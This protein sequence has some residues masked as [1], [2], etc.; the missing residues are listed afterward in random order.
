M[1]VNPDKI[2]YTEITPNN[3]INHSSAPIGFLFIITAI[4]N[5]AAIKLKISKD[6]TL[7]PENM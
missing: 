5:N 1:K 7:W 6:S 2:R 3:P 4:P